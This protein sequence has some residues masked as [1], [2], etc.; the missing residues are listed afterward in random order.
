MSAGKLCPACGKDIGVWPIFSAGL[1]NRIW[2]PHCRARLAYRNAWAV[3]LVVLGVMAGVVAA[4]YYAATALPDARPAVRALAFGG[5]VLGAW[6]PVELAVA[7]FLRQHRELAV[8]DGSR[9]ASG[10]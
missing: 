6:V 10:D 9:P 2:C 1:P 8:V 5:V 4:G 7:W 3:F